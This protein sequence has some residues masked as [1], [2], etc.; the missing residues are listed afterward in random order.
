MHGENRTTLVP[1]VI[2]CVDFKNEIHFMI[3]VKLEQLFTFKVRITNIL[4]FELLFDEAGNPRQ[5]PG[6][7]RQI[8]EG[9]ES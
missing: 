9:L 4:N 6:G 1:G 3:G 8:Q 7:G 5:I 2:A